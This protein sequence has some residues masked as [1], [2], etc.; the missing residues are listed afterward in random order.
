[1]PAVAKQF[2]SVA[3]NT[4]TLRTIGLPERTFHAAKTRAPSARSITDPYR[5]VPPSSSAMAF[6]PLLRP[7][8]E[9][10]QCGTELAAEIGE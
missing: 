1:V 10:C 2:S 6:G 8:I 4:R 3:N 5:A 7:R 9:G